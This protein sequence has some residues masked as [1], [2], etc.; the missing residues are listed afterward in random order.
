MPEFRTPG[1]YVEE[2]SSGPRPVQASSTTETGMVGMVTIPKGFLA[3]RRSKDLLIPQ[4]DLHPALTWQRAVAF[5]ALPGDDETKSPDVKSPDVKNPDVKN[6]DVKSPDVKSPDV[7]SPDV[8][9]PDVKADARRPQRAEAPKLHRMVKDLLGSNWSVAAPD[10]TGMVALSDGSQTI[11]FAARRTLIAEKDDGRIWDIAAGA[12]TLEVVNLV[13]V[14][15]QQLGISHSGDLTCAT[16]TS[17]DVTIETVHDRMMKTASRVTSVD[18]FEGWL[19]DL[20]Q[21]LFVNIY[22]E[23]ARDA[24]EAQAGTAW[25]GLEPESRQAWRQWVRSNP[26]VRLLEIGVRGFFANGGQGIH[27]AV[28]VQGFGSAG[29]D[30]AQLLGQAFDGITQLAMI[31][32]P[33]LTSPN[34]VTSPL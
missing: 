13:A 28:G 1:V 5:Y 29:P 7:K 23:T 8:K 15:A 6:P 20:A 17:R 3:A 31:C 32:A 24:S 12:N 33:G 9:S 16:T 34:T 14:Y 25:L 27:L 2:I 19:D 30:K 10:R 18:G 22:L 21:D 11:R 26:G 4:K